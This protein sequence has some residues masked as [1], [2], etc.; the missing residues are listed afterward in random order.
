MYFCKGYEYA[1]KVDLS[2][3]YLLVTKRFSIIL[4]DFPVPV[5]GDWGRV[6]SIMVCNMC[7]ASLQVSSKSALGFSCKFSLSRASKACKYFIFFSWFSIS[8]R[9]VYCPFFFQV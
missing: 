6:L 2:K 4:V 1:E 8:F 9:F 5:L 7:S 3:G